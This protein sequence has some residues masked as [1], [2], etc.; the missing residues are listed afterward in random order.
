M[1]TTAYKLFVLVHS[2]DP[3]FGF[4][5]GPIDNTYWHEQVQTLAAHIIAGT[6]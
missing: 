1:S 2:P 6:Y 5:Y 4:G 3:V